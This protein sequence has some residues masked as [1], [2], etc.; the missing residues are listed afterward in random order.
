M[1]LAQFSITYAEGE[2]WVVFD[3]GEQA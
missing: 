2:D 1:F 3:T